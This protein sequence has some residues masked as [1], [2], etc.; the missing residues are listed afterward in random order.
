MTSHNPSHPQP[1]TATKLIGRPLTF[2]PKVDS[3]QN[4]V[5]QAALA[6]A[7]EG[8]VVAA[9]CQTAGRGR[10]GRDWWSPPRGGLYVSLLLR[11]RLTPDRLAWMT[12]IVALGAAEAIE[13]VCGVTPALKWPNDLTWQ[14]RKLAGV[15]AESSI[16]DGEVDF[17]IAGIGIN[18]QVD[19]S[20]R[21][22]LAGQAVSLH[23]IADGPVAVEPILEALLARIETHYLASQ[24]G[25]SPQPLWAARLATLGQQ[26]T[27]TL[28]D[29][30]TRHGVAEAVLDDGRLQLRLADGSALAVSAADVSLSRPLPCNDGETPPP[31]TDRHAAA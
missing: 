1:A 3:T 31:P 2:L 13:A 8:L 21:P 10:L 9:G 12:M 24:R 20:A 22:D 23:E 27:A 30:S 29:G 19:F 14:S 28:A 16:V 11:P 17:V 18:V 5:R 7:P 26:V 6:G 4:V 15:L 25:V